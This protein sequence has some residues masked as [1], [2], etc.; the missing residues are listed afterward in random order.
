MASITVENPGLLTSLQDKG[1]FGYGAAGIP[2]GGAMD[3]LAMS[4]AN[5]VLGND[6]DEAVLE[7]TIMGPTL[8]FD[9]S[10]IIAI[11]GAD[12]S[13]MINGRSIDMYTAYYVSQGDVLSFGQRNSGSRSYIAVR[14]GYNVPRVMDSKSTYLRG[15]F[16]GYE[17][18]KVAKGDRIK[19]AYDN[20]RYIGN[21]SL[22]PS[23]RPVYGSDIRVRIIWG[24]EKDRFTEDS[25][26]ILT[27]N[28]YV[29]SSHSDRMGYRLEGVK[30]EHTDGADIISSGITFGAIQIPGH[31]QPI[32]MMA[33]RQTTGGYTKIANVISVDLPY[34][35]Q[36]KAG[37]SISFEAID[38]YTAHELMREQEKWLGEIEQDM[39]VTY[40]VGNIIG[41]RSF[42]INV[43]SKSYDI[44]LF[45]IE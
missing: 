40:K 8:R 39:K 33:D 23:N 44:R 20:H 1:R 16:G 12:L 25:R 28:K 45:E 15:G 31:G 2:I 22:K 26:D 7:A 37:D 10:T 5:I 41:D 6:R 19:L 18:R 34:L 35:A 21:R 13:P 32:I 38:V 43:D 24:E 27:S 3:Y 9:S 29:L 14:G 11:G 4:L 36:L 42:K 17:G 30:L